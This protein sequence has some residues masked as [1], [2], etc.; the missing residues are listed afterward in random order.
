MNPSVDPDFC[1]FGLRKSG[2]PSAGHSRMSNRKFGL[3]LGVLFLMIG[4]VFWFLAGLRLDW[5]FVAGGIFLSVAAIVP[6]ILLPVNLIWHNVAKHVRT[7]TNWVVLGSIFYF[8][9]TPTGLALRLF[10]HDPLVRRKGQPVDSYF[11]PVQR[12]TDAKTM[13]DWF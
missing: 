12:Q 8:V 10:G 1:K 11:T 5:A 3:A 4:L 9:I 2:A 13:H 7:V 6:A